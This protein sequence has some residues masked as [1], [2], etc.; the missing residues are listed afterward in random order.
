MLITAS[1]GS[2][3]LQIRLCPSPPGGGRDFPAA[4]LH[5]SG[6]V[7]LTATLVTP[8]TYSHSQR[9]R[10]VVHEAGFSCTPPAIFH[11]KDGDRT[12]V[13]A[14]TQ[15][16]KSGRRG[17]HTPVPRL[18]SH[19]ISRE[20][21]ARAQ[22]ILQQGTPESTRR[23]HQEDIGLFWTW[24]FATYDTRIPQ[25]YPV[26]EGVLVSYIT[27]CLTGIPAKV[28]SRMHDLRHQTYPQDE[29]PNR[30]RDSVR[31][32]CRPQVR[33]QVRGERMKAVHSISTVSRRVASLSWAH[34][35]QGIQN[36]CTSPAVKYLLTQARR[37]ALR[38]GWRQNRK[39]ALVRPL[40]CQILATCNSSPNTEPIQKLRNLR[41]RA[42]F[43]LAFNA[44]GRRRMEI[45][46]ARVNELTRN[47]RGYVF[48]LP[49]SK[50][51]PQG[52]G[53]AV[54]IFGEAASAL[55]AWLEN[56]NITSGYVFRPIDR[57]GCISSG[58]LSGSGVAF[59]FKKRAL[60]AQID[61]K[62]FSFH[63]IRAGFLTQAADDGISLPESMEVSGH[64]SYEVARRYYR[65]ADISKN[66]AADLMGA[67]LTGARVLKLDLVEAVQ[68]VAP[69]AA[70]HEKDSFFSEAE[71]RIRKRLDEKLVMVIRELG[72]AHKRPT[73]NL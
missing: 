52:R 58:R 43:L 64:R 45:A 38:A 46:C 15:N 14:H 35:V 25:E 67:H 30:R 18:P 3:F 55:A 69:H 65:K 48:T 28:L 40:L 2:R 11:P 63:S 7:T 24:V 44:G 42:M 36:P 4:A 19:N 8:N 47:S 20:D 61:P 51:D 68:R 59:I 22:A 57:Y 5:V 53:H 60:E 72:E 29:T 31:G 13:R 32:Q 49:I 41:D 16:K 6:E 23:A 66:R 37:G 34:R 50:T 27:Q 73:D 71:S 1:L 70:Q 10:A 21:R 12:L 17:S 54:P 62:R 9:A 33:A 56:S 26:P 39:D